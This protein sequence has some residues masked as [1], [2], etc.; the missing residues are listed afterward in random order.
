M[1]DTVREIGDNAFDGCESLSVVKIAETSGLIA[2][3]DQAFAHTNI[4]AFAFPAGLLDVGQE[5]F[6]YTALDTF[7]LPASVEYVGPGVLKGTTPTK[8]TLSFLGYAP[9]DYETATLVY[10][11]DRPGA[12]PS[13]LPDT[14]KSVH[15]LNC[16]ILYA[17]AFEGADTLECVTLET[18][19]VIAGRAFSHCKALP[20]RSHTGERSLR[21]HL[22]ILWLRGT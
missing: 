7:A 20:G 16:P 1:P 3:G 9:G 17:S 18:P 5:A 6:S 19:T 10:T 4:S 2:I 8:L 21:R 15:V 22:C 14:L 13:V 11:F 12:D